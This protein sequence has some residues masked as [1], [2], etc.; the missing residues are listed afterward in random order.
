ME[1]EIVAACYPR[2][3]PDVSIREIKR[4]KE[5]SKGRYWDDKYYRQF[6]SV[7]PDGV[8][9]LF[10]YCHGPKDDGYEECGCEKTKFSYSELKKTARNWARGK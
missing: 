10:D 9:K 4:V 2:L 6:V 3:L 1:K 7:S 8:R 5:K